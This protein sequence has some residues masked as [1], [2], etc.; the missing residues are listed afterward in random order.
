[1]FQF[2]GGT[3]K[4][5]FALAVWWRCRLAPRHGQTDS[6]DASRFDRATLPFSPKGDTFLQPRV[7]R[8]ERTG[9]P[10]NA[11][12][13]NRLSL[14]GI[15]NRGITDSAPTPF[16]RFMHPFQGRFPKRSASPG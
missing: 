10:G 7:A 8:S 11:N 5:S 9:Y 15:Y 3:V 13:D 1:M 6:K 14:K 12:H 2:P 4:A 16:P